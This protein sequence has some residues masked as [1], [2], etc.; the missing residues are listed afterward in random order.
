MLDFVNGTTWFFS[1][2][3]TTLILTTLLV[4]AVLFARWTEH[5]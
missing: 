2:L 5:R 4:V 1:G 3:G